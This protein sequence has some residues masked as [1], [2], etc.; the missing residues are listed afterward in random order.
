MAVDP[1]AVI[2]PP[3]PAPAIGVPLTVPTSSTASW[4]PQG[5]ARAAANRIAAR[6]ATGGGY[7]P[8]QNTSIPPEGRALLGVIGSQGFESNGSYTQRFNQPDLQDFSQH[9]GTYGKITGGPNRGSRSNAAGRY[10]FLSTTYKEQADKLGLKDFSPQ[11]Q[12]AAAWNKAQEVYAAKYKGRDLATDLK[13]P[14]RMTQVTNALR[15]IWT[16]LPG[17][18]EQRGKFKQF[19]QGYQKALQSEMARTGGG[20][21]YAAP[22]PPPP[23][24]GRRPSPLYNDTQLTQSFPS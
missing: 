5:V 6:Q 2:T 24:P 23:P 8:V 16:S 9:P 20:P 13:A 4:D 3:T 11:S 10:Q 15:S 19:S 18:I 14:N 21:Q 1:N 7:A 17:G 12:D 22:S